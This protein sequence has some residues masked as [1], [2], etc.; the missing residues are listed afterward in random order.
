MVSEAPAEPLLSIVVPTRNRPECVESLLRGLCASGADN[1]EIVVQDNSSDDSLGARLAA[2]ADPRIRYEHVA[3]PLNMHQNFDRAVARAK[4]HYACALGDDDAVIVDEALTV[5]ERARARDVDA[6]LTGLAFYYWPGVIHRFWGDT[7]GLLTDFE[8]KS[9]DREILLDPREELRRVF[10]SGV[11]NGL[12]RLPRVYQGFVSRRSLNA[13]FDKCGSYFP[14][15]SPDMANAVALAPFVNSTLYTEQPIVISGYS[16]RSGGS[17]GAS[18][19]HHGRLE[20]Q[21]HLP[22][23]TLEH[24]D[25]AIPRFWSGVT[26][27]AQSALAAARAVLHPPLPPIGYHRLY[28]ACLIFEPRPYRPAVF[29]AARHRGGGA[30]LYARIGAAMAGMVAA[31]GATF[32]RNLVKLRGGAATRASYANTAEVMLAG[33]LRAAGAVR[34]LSPSA[35][36]AG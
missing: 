19:K 33:G 16:P 34:A 9:G 5:L 20:D 4:G 31:R 25:D 2:T 3:E 24:W 17:A 30:L 27:Y 12:G 21:P 13:L 1:F 35:R 11:T 6:V 10:A 28:A 18:G 22:A 23:G 29:A 36:A 15:P 7:G 14:G 32:A 26:I 8:T